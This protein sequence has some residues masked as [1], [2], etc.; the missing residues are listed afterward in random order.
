MTVAVGVFLSQIFAFRTGS[1]NLPYY[2]AVTVGNRLYFIRGRS[3]AY[4]DEQSDSAHLIKMMNKEGTCSIV[5][6][7]NDIYAGNGYQIYHYDSSADT[8]GFLYS[9]RDNVR[10]RLFAANDRYLYYSQAVSDASGAHIQV[11]RYSLQTKENIKLPIPID[12]SDISSPILVG[13]FI[14]FTLKDANGS[15]V[16]H[17]IYRVKDDGSSMETVASFS[18]VVCLVSNGDNAAFIAGGQESG[19]IYSLYSIDTQRNAYTEVHMNS[20]NFSLENMNSYF[21]PSQH[22]I[23]SAKSNDLFQY[24][25]FDLSSLSLSPINVEIPVSGVFAGES[26]YY[27]YDQGPPAKMYKQHRGEDTIT[28]IQ[29]PN[30][31]NYIDP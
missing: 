28:G 13:G 29:L 9:N 23:F 19:G 26:V 17:D 27:L 24:Y 4:C 12:N 14:Y 8:T 1:G 21:A 31:G 15:P 2:A 6:Y 5:A 25:V 18:P 30:S 3:F 11:M 10:I 7:G 16:Y 20:I 22:V